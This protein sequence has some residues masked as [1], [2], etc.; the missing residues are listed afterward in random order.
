MLV[1]SKTECIVTDVKTKGVL[2]CQGG[3]SITTCISLD[4]DMVSH[5]IDHMQ[6]PMAVQSNEGSF[7][8]CY[9]LW[10]VKQKGKQMIIILATES[11]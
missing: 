2:R 3:D 10:S 1:I 4:S 5:A 7:T 11:F 8:S 9:L 6:H